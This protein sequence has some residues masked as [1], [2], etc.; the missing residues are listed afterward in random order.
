MLA[1]GTKKDTPS[2]ALY[3]LR[4]SGL[5][6]HEHVTDTICGMGFAPFYADPDVWVQANDSV[7]EYSS[8]CR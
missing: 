2:L 4:T 7:Y 3:G 8:V 5:H 6:W 1:L